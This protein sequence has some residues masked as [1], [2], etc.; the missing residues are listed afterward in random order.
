VRYRGLP[1]RERLRR[2]GLLGVSLVP[3]A[4]V[5]GRKWANAIM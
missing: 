4:V 5:S 2:S 1:R 3:L